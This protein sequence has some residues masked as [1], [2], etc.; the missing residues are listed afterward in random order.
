MDHISR[1]LPGVLR[2]RGIGVHAHAAM[3]VYRAQKWLNERLPGL[4]DALRVVEL[5][6]GVLLI[7]SAHSIAAQECQSVAQDLIEFLQ[8]EASSHIREI[9]IVR[10]T[11]PL[12]RA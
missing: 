1:V 12:E 2:K 6:D 8:K 10:G 9:R 3:L 5:K 11:K 4:A 7:E